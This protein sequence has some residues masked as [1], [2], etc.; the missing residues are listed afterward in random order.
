MPLPKELNPKER[1]N[2]IRDFRV[3]DSSELNQYPCGSFFFYFDQ[4]KFQV[5][6][7]KEQIPF[8]VAK[9]NAVYNGVFTYQTTKYDWIKNKMF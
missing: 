2:V 3:R 5:Q 4:L 1:R 8:T 9:L 7:E 6:I